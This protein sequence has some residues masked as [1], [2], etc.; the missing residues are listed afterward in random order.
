LCLK[1]TK[2]LKNG[3][4]DKVLDILSQCDKVDKSKFIFGALER[5]NTKVLPRMS[6]TSIVDNGLTYSI[7][8]LAAL[9]TVLTPAVLA[10]DFGP[11][12]RVFGEIAAAGKRSYFTGNSEPNYTAAIWAS[13]LAASPPAS[14]S[15][16]DPV[17]IRSVIALALQGGGMSAAA[18]TDK[19][20]FLCRAQ[21][22][23]HMDFLAATIVAAVVTAGV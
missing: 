3:A 10:Q 15:Q 16:I 1:A 9:A 2:T 21:L 7:A 19:A 20:E 23:R 17:S 13:V 5:S 22:N 11:Q 18:A 12:D 4:H 8:S 6:M 14:L